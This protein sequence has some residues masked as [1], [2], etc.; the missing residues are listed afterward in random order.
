MGVYLNPRHQTFELYIKVPQTGD[1]NK[2]HHEN[3]T[4]GKKKREPNWFSHI[5]WS[6]L[7]TKVFTPSFGF[8]LPATP[9]LLI[10]FINSSHVRINLANLV[11]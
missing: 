2:S 1:E 4:Q 10:F 6:S 9:L 3:R 5:N 11:N 7:L 8:A